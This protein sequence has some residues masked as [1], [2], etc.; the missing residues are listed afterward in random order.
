M[1]NLSFSY[2]DSVNFDRLKILS[3]D[4]DLV[5]FMDSFNF[6]VG[7]LL[8]PEIVNG[9]MPILDPLSISIKNISESFIMVSF[10]RWILTATP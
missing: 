4:F 3:I 8:F 9:L 2:V 5:S 10:I 7:T 1:A 6:H